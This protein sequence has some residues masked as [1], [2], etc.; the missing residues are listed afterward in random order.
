MD[1]LLDDLVGRFRAAQDAAVIFLRDVI[2]LPRPKS[3]IDWALHIREHV[4]QASVPAGVTLRPHGYGI[5]VVTET[6]NVDFDWGDRGELDGFDG[7]RLHWFSLQNPSKVEYSH[8]QLNELLELAVRGGA[9]I[10][11][12]SLYFDPKRRASP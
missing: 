7:W 12:G 2:K 10:K 1:P 5:E 4:R 3:N 11:S 8:A 6:I 9:L